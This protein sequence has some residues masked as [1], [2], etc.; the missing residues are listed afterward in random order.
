MEDSYVATYSTLARV[1]RFDRQR[2]GENKRVWHPR[3]PGLRPKTIK[4]LPPCSPSLS[5]LLFHTYFLTSLPPK[6]ERDYFIDASRWLLLAFKNNVYFRS[7]TIVVGYKILDERLSVSGC[8]CH[9]PWQKILQVP[10]TS[11]GDKTSWFLGG[12]QAVS[13]RSKLSFSKTSLSKT[14]FNRILPK[15]LVASFNK[16][17]SRC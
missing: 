10:A 13:V 4:P 7:Q 1:V 15:L 11:L 3:T 16:T 12:K 17:S 8:V 9:V 14:S 5:P 2:W 6:R